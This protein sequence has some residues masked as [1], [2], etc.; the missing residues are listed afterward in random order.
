MSEMYRIVSHHMGR[1][2]QMPFHPD[3][4]VIP[5]APLGLS[6]QSDVILERM[7]Y[8]CD[9]AELPSVLVDELKTPQWGEFLHCFFS[10]AF[11]N[12]RRVRQAVLEHLLPDYEPS[13]AR[14]LSRHGQ[15]TADRKLTFHKLKELLDLCSRRHTQVM[16][17]AMPLRSNYEIPSELLAIV[18]QHETTLL[19]MR[20]T[21]G[22]GPTGFKDG[23]HMNAEGAKVFSNAFVNR[24]AQECDAKKL[25]GARHRP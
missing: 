5:F 17:V 16:L 20:N 23:S 9:F 3:L 22:L 25:R 10:N 14:L 4:L 1:L 7:A 12:R 19:D 21:P 8:H 18:Q 2:D 24:F 6:D 13:V 15:P 11:S